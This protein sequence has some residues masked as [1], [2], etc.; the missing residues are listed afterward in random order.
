MDIWQA[1]KHLTGRLQAWAGF[2]LLSGLA[3]VLIAGLSPRRPF[4]RGLGAQFIGWGAI[5]AA[6][7][8]IGGRAAQARQAALPDPGDPLIQAGERR[9]LLRLLGINS[10]L[11]IGYVLGGGYLA[12]AEA[13]ERRGHGLGVIIQGAFLFFFDL[14]HALRLAGPHQKS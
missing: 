3:L 14:F 6:I 9:S 8:A 11:D 4:L 7:A 13:P 1:Q 10:L 5:N 2:S 12:R